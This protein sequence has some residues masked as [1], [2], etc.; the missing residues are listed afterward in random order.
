LEDTFDLLFGVSDT[1]R[2]N[3]KHGLS[4]GQARTV[5]NLADASLTATLAKVE[6]KERKKRDKQ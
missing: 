6:P 3:G 4:F 5:V 2:Q 1:V